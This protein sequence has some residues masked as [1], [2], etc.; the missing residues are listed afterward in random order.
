MTDY[1]IGYGSLINKDGRFTTSVTGN[2]IPV[3]LKHYK[4]S[5]NAHINKFNEK[6]AVSVEKSFNDTINAIMVTLIP[7]I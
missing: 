2:C 4:R 6:Y 7:K 5:W 1:V 3:N